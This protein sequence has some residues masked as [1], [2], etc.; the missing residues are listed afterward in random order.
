MGGEG[1]G[2]FGGEDLMG[3]GLMVCWEGGADS[4]ANKICI[5]DAIEGLGRRLEWWAVLGY[6]EKYG[7]NN[8]RVVY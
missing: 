7:V 1:G 2:G 3:G 8:L 5:K 4:L 6:L